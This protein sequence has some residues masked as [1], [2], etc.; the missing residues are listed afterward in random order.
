MNKS[1]HWE[2]RHP[3]T[4]AWVTK[5]YWE[6]IQADVRQAVEAMARDEWTEIS[7]ATLRRHIAELKAQVGAGGEADVT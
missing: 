2:D 3:N 4:P 6:L 1:P 5:E 7:L